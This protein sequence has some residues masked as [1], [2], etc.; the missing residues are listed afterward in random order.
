[1]IERKIPGKGWFKIPGVQEGDRS[2]NEQMLGLD[3]A[4]A[5]A[6]GKTVA[7]YGSAEGLIAFEF[8]KAGATSVY[9]CE[10]VSGH[11]EVAK[12]IA[13][14]KDR[15][16]CRFECINIDTLVKRERERGEIW[17]YD[18]SLALAI[19]HKL[20][21]PEAAIDFIADATREMIVV[22]FPIGR[23]GSFRDV[24]SQDRFIDVDARLSVK[25]FKV[26]QV[27]TGPRTEKVVYY[28]RKK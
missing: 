19:L 21:N 15:C 11:V 12:S 13:A 27:E 7:D 26:L 24:R 9:G 25:G 10:I 3:L 22:R 5:S 17:P 14:E 4:L 23:C 28:V 1:M 8:D 20:S 2:L 18:I 6:K 16:V